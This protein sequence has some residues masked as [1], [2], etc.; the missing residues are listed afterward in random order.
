MFTVY[1]LKSIKHVYHY[2]GHTKNLD[3]RL[4]A[5]N[6]GKVRSTKA[7]RPYKVIY[8]ENY[9]TRAEAFKREM[10]LKSGKGNL[11]LINKLW[12]TVDI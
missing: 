6:Y 8:M 11:W 12:I 5:H 3:G 4:K 9:K 1:V 7:Y 2:I 10:F